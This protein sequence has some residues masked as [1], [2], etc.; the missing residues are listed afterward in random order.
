MR[1][2]CIATNRTRLERA[3]VERMFE[4]G[5]DATE[6]SD[7]VAITMMVFGLPRPFAATDAIVVLPGQGEDWRLIDA[8][9]AWNTSPN[10]RYLLVAGS[11]SGETTWFLPTVKI[12]Q[13]RYGL[14]RTDGLIIADHAHHT[15]EQAVWFVE[16]VQSLKLHSVSLFVSPYHLLRAYGTL[17]KAVLDAGIWIPMIPMP[18]HVSP[19]TPIPETGFTAWQLVAGEVRRFKQYRDVE[20]HVVSLAELQHYLEWLWTQPIISQ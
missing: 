7:L 2:S 20:R 13:E 19:E 6:E 9:K 5:V 8:V 1:L 18:V 10:V 14:T 11:F 15:R 16:M 12:L 3:Y 17:L 4:R